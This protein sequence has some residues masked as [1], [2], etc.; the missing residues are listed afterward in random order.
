MNFRN[1]IELN[2]YFSTEEICRKHL[3]LARWNGTPACPFCGSV[4]VYRFSDGRRF[5]C[6]EK[7]C[8]KKFTVTVGTI[9]ENSKIPLR[10]WFAA[11]YLITAHKKGISSLQLSRDISVTQKS[12]WFLLHRVRLML[13]ENEPKLLTGTVAMDEV[14][15]GGKEKNRHANK[16]G[17]K[18]TGRSL[19]TKTPVLGIFQQNGVVRAFVVSSGEAP[20]L[21]PKMYENIDRSATIV[22]DAYSAYNSL[23]KHFAK[24]IVVN[25][26][27]GEYV[28]ENGFTTNNIE[29]FWGLLK[30]GIIGIYHY[31]SE[32]HLDRY[33]NEFTYRYNSRQKTDAERFDASLTQC[34]KRLKYKDLIHNTPKE[35][36]VDFLDKTKSNSW[37]SRNRRRKN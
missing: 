25:H 11:T 36:Y 29:N 23:S 5:K 12:A 30:R 34:E 15:I 17:K 27:K 33:V 20:N 24:H 16:R 31:T 9:Y 37:A 19:D 8:N 21:L 1:L 4:H 6:A 10:K 3:E 35:N 26:Q 2:D 32:K 7:Q 18:R 28:N 13:T 22:T 14:Y